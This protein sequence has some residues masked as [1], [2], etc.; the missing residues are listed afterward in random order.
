M[1]FTSRNFC[2]AGQS[3]FL[4]PGPALTMYIRCNVCIFLN[5]YITTSLIFYMNYDP[6]KTNSYLIELPQGSNWCLSLSR[7]PGDLQQ[8]AWNFSCP[9]IQMNINLPIFASSHSKRKNKLGG[10]IITKMEVSTYQALRIKYS[11]CRTYLSL[12][13]NW[14]SREFFL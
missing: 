10:K 13:S 14:T 3:I 7:K 6:P 12:C 5:S 2:A 1:V 4:K 8:C 9:V 11:C